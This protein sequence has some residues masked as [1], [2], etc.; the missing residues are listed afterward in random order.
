MILLRVFFAS[1]LANAIALYIVARF[2][3]GIRIENLVP[4]GG[5]F[6][7]A[8]G[9][10]S[11][12]IGSLVLSILNAVLRPV[13]NFLSLPLTCL[14]LGLFSF[15]ITGVVFYLGAMFTPGM[16]VQGFGWAILGGVGFGIL[17]SIISGL[18]GVKKEKKK[19]N[20]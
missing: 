2:I 10:V 3:P 17:N 5:G 14:T 16:H 9:I 19:N 6:I 12:L 1:W 4:E 8:T 13:L 11:I 18:L 7:T 20:S 15:V